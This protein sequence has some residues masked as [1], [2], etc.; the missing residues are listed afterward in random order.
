MRNFSFIAFVLHCTLSST[1]FGQFTTIINVPPSPAPSFLASNTQVNVLA[2]GVVGDD[3]LVGASDG[4][5]TNVEFNLLG[6]EVGW[7]LRIQAGGTANISG[8]SNGSGVF[9]E[10][11]ELNLS[12]GRVLGRVDVIDGGKLNMS[13]G[14]IELTSFGSLQIGD[15]EVNL[16]GGV[17]GE[18]MVTGGVVNISG[19]RFGPRAI[20]S[21]GTV[22]FFGGE[23]KLDGT[24]I[25]GLDAM[26]ESMPFNVPVGSILTGTL[27][28]GSTF[29]IG[30]LPIYHRD[31]IGSG[32]IQLHRAALPALGTTT[33][34]FPPL[35][36]P[37]GVRGGQTLNLSGRGALG[38]SFSVAPGGTLNVRGGSVASGLEAVKGKVTLTNGSIGSLAALLGSEVIVSAGTMGALELVGGST[39]RITGGSVYELS[40][41]DSD[42]TILGGR[43][44]RLILRSGSTANIGGTTRFQAGVY[45]DASLRIAGGTNQGVAV[46]SGGRVEIQGG[47]FEK[48]LSAMVGSEVSFLAK[49]FAL[50]GVP[51]NDLPA[52]AS[53]DLTGIRG[54]LTGLFADNTPFEFRLGIPC[55]RGCSVG[56]V[57]T[58]ATVTIA[59]MAVPEPT[60]ALM[61]AVAISAAV[62]G[63][64]RKGRTSAMG[65]R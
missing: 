65:M 25:A 3:L 10:G 47:V 27:A 44:D 9:V 29:S 64:H 26:G 2:A 18:G 14:I 53:R 59:M 38:E 60:T 20:L 32:V 31:R 30:D 23:F 40:S 42:A 8:G 63:K 45:D 12:G 61:M 54:I 16:S 55:D 43:V 56:V 52:G 5:K 39:A 36:A 6:G 51:I 24:P 35:P 13:G 22:N 21:S 19:G 37:T 62:L 34:E 33:V 4:S 1:A 50:D 28:D 15:G 58:G 57:A 11:G 17:V 49:S 46:D 48:G 7:R 41:L